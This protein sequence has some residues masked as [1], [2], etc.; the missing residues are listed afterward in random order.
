MTTDPAAETFEG[1]ADVDGLAVVII[2]GVDAPS[3]AP[4]APP[5]VVS[6]LEEVLDLLAD[7]DDVR[8]RT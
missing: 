3:V 2:E 4:D 5:V 6:R 7:G 1:L 8:W